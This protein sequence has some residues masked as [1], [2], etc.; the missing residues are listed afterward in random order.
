MTLR[1]VKPGDKP[2]P[3]K[4]ITQAAESGS[5]RD[6][7]VAMRTRI[8]KTVE[9]SDCP[10]RDL[11]ALTR[12]LQ[13]IAKEIEGIDARIAEEAKESAASPDEKWDAEAL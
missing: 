2:P 3:R 5:H 11:A 10:P 4:S 1:A 6:L 13:E 7:L 9:K 8:A 12:R